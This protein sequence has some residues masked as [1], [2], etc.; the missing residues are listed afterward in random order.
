MAIYHFSAQVISRGKGQSA[1]A[2]ASYRSGQRLVDE[3]TGETKYYVREVQP[4][5][6]ILTPQNSPQWIQNRELL[7][8]EVERS[9][10]RKDSQLAREINVAL[11]REL[12]HDQQRELIRDYVQ[13]EFVDKGMVADIAIHRDDKE[14]PHAHV[15]LTTREIDDDGFGAK[16]RD[17][18]KRELLEQWRAEWSNHANQ[19]LERAGFQE[20][21]SHLSH[22]A[23]GLEQLPTI[24]LG[25]VAAE[26]EKR[27]VETEKGN[28]NRDRQEYNALVIDLDTYRQEKQAL[29]KE[30]ER[31]KEEKQKANQFN[32]PAELVDLKNAAI[33]LKTEV[34]LANLK[35]RYI[36][37]DNWEERLNKNDGF[38]RWKDQTI[39]ETSEHFK[40]IHSFQKQI[41][42]TE[43]QIENINWFN[44]LKLKENRNFK[45]KAKQDISKAKDEITFHKK[46]MNYYHNKLG[47][48]NEKEFT[49][50]KEQH[51]TE[52]PG[53]ISKNKDTRKYI[54]SE[55]DTLKKAEIAL[56][57]A[58]VRKTATLYPERPEMAYI[59]YKTAKQIVEIN[60]KY[61]KDNNIVPIENMEKA[62]DYQ[63]REIQ[64]LQKEI[65]NIEQNKAR[66]Q[67][68]KNYLNELEKQQ[69]IVEKHENNPFLKGKI[70]VS[71]ST[72]HEYDTAV[73]ER[74]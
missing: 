31:K 19:A 6:M 30:Q 63:K 21:I 7:W 39:K 38:N 33:F 64:R 22:D 4:D 69:A 68:V 52:Y 57:K 11:P 41:Q 47:F 20:R 26:M 29:L 71:K 56:K 14:N 55:R 12:N 43:K 13:K 59:S 67:R 27:G 62:I 74:N 5:T 9:E 50:L 25:H 45:E 46:K 3:R 28:V 42:E 54:D 23:R 66:M 58:F 44:P 35:K 72:K 73:T 37:L 70:L 49:Q 18:N 36:Q 10:K 53:L 34:S 16:N 17:W 1:V 51:D 65:S 2:S 32:T 24:H 48:N 60:K 40:W 15:M 61:G 8:N